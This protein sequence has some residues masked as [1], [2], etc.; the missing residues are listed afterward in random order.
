MPVASVRIDGR[1]DPVL[2]HPP[3]DPERPVLVVLEI[4][5][6]HRGQQGRGLADCLRQPHALQRHQQRQRVIRERLN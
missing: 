2:G 6:D 1:D 3:G 5:P 4:L